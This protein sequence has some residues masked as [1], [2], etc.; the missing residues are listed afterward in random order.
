MPWVSTQ[1]LVGFLGEAARADKIL[2]QPL[3]VEPWPAENTPR[4][5][6]MATLHTV[7]RRSRPGHAVR[8]W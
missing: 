4:V 6:T 5:R 3:G 7:P 2:P 1:R 8:D